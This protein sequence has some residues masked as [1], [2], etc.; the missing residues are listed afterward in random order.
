MSA[1][2]IDVVSFGRSSDL[3]MILVLG[4]IGWL[5]GGMLGTALF[6]ISREI[7]ADLNPIYWQFWLG[8]LLILLVLFAKG[9]ARGLFVAAYRGM[10]AKWA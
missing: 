4:G 5:Y 9:G 3:L 7:L 2:G 6:L 1:V 10:T 8:L